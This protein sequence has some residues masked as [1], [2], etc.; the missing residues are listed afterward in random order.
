MDPFYTGQA[1]YTPGKAMKSIFVHVVYQIQG[2][3]WSD[4]VIVRNGIATTLCVL[5]YLPGLAEVY[6]LP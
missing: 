4:V 2:M 1:K 3:K 6:I 5:V